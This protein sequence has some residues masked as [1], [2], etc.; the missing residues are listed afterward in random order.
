MA[1]GGPPRTGRTAPKAP[2]ANFWQETGRGGTDAPETGR[3]CT[4]T[5]DMKRPAAASATG[6]L[7]GRAARYLALFVVVR[8]QRVQTSALTGTP[9][10]LM[11]SGWRFGW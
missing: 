11:M 8:R 10:W 4:D 9:F 7:E 2:Q 1:A 5:Q 3:G 6:Q